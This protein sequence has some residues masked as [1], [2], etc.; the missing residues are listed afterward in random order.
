MSNAVSAQRITTD[1]RRFECGLWRMPQGDIDAAYCADI[2]PKLKVFTHEGRVYTNG[3]CGFSHFIKAT[4]NCYPLISPDEYSGPTE[5]P[6]S[7][8]GKEGKWSG[9][10]Y[11][12][13]PL[14]I[15]EASDPSVSEWIQLYRVMF[16]DGRM[17]AS[18][19]TYEGFLKERMEPESQNECEAHALEIA[20][21]LSEAMPNSQEEMGRLLGSRP[22]H[23]AAPKRQQL[24]LSL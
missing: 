10:A 21:C 16:A 24:D 2:F 20:R 3:G 9:K 8:E 11:R 19:V 18:G 1:W 17:F 7:Y 23:E 13:G 22:A 14:V 12:L 5:V 4:A 15:F 6:Y